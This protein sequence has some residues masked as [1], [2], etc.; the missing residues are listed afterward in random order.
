[1][2]GDKTWILR[3]LNCNDNIIVSD[4]RF[5]V[6]YEEVKQRNGITIYIDRGGVPGSHQSEREVVDL[7][8]DNKFDYVINNNGTLRDLFY[9]TSK[10]LKLWQKAQ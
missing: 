1:M 4:L 6:E 9:K 5:K 8:N 7:A 3:T 2:F 10:L